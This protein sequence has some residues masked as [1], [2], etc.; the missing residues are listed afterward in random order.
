MIALS[1]RH[2]SLKLLPQLFA[3]RGAPRRAASV[4]VSGAKAYL[5][6]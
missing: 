2:L 6:I 3:E 4:Y 5:S 1:T